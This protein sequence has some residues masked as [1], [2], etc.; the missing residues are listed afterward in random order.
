M[1]PANVMQSGQSYT[2]M[3]ILP[4]QLHALLSTLCR[5]R[6]RHLMDV[7]MILTMIIVHTWV[8]CRPYWQCK[9]W[10]FLCCQKQ[11]PL[12]P[13]GHIFWNG[14]NLLNIYCWIHWL[15]LILLWVNTGCFT[16]SNKLLSFRWWNSFRWI[17]V[18]YCCFTAITPLSCGAKKA[19]LQVSL[20]V[21]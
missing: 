1:H 17:Q 19:S 14:Y 18:S 20:Q 3:C 12:V 9:L 7:S 8:F 10:V 6:H 21:S 13:L 16:C 4:L 15:Y 5:N 2:K 11:T